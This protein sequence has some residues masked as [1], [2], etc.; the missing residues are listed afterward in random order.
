MTE[1]ADTF[2]ERLRLI[3]LRRFPSHSFSL[4]FLNIKAETSAVNPFTFMRYLIQHKT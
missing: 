1:S 4:G 2:V 3:F